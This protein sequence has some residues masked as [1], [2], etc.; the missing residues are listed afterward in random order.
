MVLMSR[1]WELLFPTIVSWLNPRDMPDHNPII[2]STSGSLH[3]GNR[4]FKF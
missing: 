3:V 2:I 4:D 1:E